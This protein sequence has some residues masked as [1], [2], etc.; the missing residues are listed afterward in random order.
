M[1]AQEGGA[2][3]AAQGVIGM[4]Q[5]AAQEAAQ[6]VIKNLMAE[7]LILRQKTVQTAGR[8]PRAR[9]APNRPANKCAS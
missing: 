6:G 3:K 4:V 8:A 7:N 5:K 9:L 1:S 2:L